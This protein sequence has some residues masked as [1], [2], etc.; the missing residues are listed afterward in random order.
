MSSSANAFL[1]RQLR[2][3]QTNPP[4]YFRVEADQDIFKWTVWFTGPPDTPYEGGQFKAR[5]HFPSEFPN[6]PPK[7]IILSSFFHPFVYTSGEVCI[8]ILHP[9]GE[10][11][12]NEGETAMMRWTP[13]HSIRSVLISI[14]SLIGD[15]DPKEGAPANVEAL[16]LYRNNREAYIKKCKELVQKSLAELPADFVPPSTSEKSERKGQNGASKAAPQADNDI[17]AAELQSLISMNLN[18]TLTHEDLRN[19]LHQYKG[20]VG[21]VVEKIFSS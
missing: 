13:I 12:H 8:S 21:A 10:D 11:E 14:L 17:Y 15:L 1:Q 2:E 20:D 18:T 3:I 6:L 5:M 19:L 4:A 7:F 9:P 16:S